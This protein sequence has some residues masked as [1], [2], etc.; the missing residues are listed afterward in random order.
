[1]HPPHGLNKERGQLLKMLQIERKQV[2]S[3]RCMFKRANA[4]R[5]VGYV[6]EASKD[7][8]KVYST[9]VMLLEQIHEVHTL[10]FVK[11]TEHFYTVSVA[12]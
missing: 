7:Q 11:I 8:P 1:M 6:N 2:G 12:E 4:V 3:T 9:R 5:S 10:N